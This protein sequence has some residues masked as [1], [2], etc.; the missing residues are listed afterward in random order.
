MKFTLSI[1]PAFVFLQVYSQVTIRNMS[2]VK[3]D[4]NILYKHQKNIIKVLG[5][6]QQTH[7]VSKNGSTLSTY[8]G[9]TF[10][11]TPKTLMPDTLLIFAGKEL[12][13]KQIFTIDT[14]PDPSIQLGHIQHDSATVRE[15]LANKVLHATFKGSLFFD[16]IQILS[17]ST[18][19]IGP[20]DDTLNIYIPPIE[21]NTLSKELEAIIKQLKKRS[22]IV[23]DV[24]ISITSNPKARRLA[25]YSITIH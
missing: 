11:V 1:L 25:P 16:P 15:I 24:I 8:D 13:L 22:K 12:L 10:I 5:T 9:N 21:G 3:P 4:A 7:L 14:M 23:F 6:K 19:F 18:T 17:F 2:L 20:D